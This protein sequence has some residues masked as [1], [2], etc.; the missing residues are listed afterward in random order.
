VRIFNVSK[1]RTIIIF[2][3]YESQRKGVVR[4]RIGEE[5]KEMVSF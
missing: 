3:K 4:V 1:E 5:S 2:S